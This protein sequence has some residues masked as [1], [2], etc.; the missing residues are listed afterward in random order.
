M[1]YSSPPPPASGGACTV[2]NPD[3]CRF[4]IID[5]STWDC[6]PP[7][8]AGSMCQYWNPCPPS[9]PPSDGGDDLALGL[10]VGFG[11]GAP[12][13]LL[14]IALLWWCRHRRGGAREVA[15]LSTMDT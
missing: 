4:D 3:Q 15:A 7:G 2:P 14:L 9:A 12:L 10:G 1:S 6:D 13:L 5:V 8:C 11:V